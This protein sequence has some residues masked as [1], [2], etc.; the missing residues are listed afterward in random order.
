[1]KDLDMF[2]VLNYVTYALPGLLT[3]SI[4]LIHF[5]CNVITY[6]TDG[7][8]TCLAQLV[9]LLFPICFLPFLSFILLCKPCLQS[10][11]L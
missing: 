9:S 4:Y 7:N 11:M 3:Y 10:G 5:I 6:I 8:I 1:M 2:E